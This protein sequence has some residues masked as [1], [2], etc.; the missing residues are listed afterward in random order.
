MK[1][2]KKKFG[3]LRSFIASILVLGISQSIIFPSVVE[4]RII[5]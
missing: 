3:I 2:Q 1:T 4:A 5:F